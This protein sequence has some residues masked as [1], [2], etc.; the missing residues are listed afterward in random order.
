[1]PRPSQEIRTL[2]ATILS[3]YPDSSPI[4]DILGSVLR[5]L[6]A[7]QLVLVVVSHPGELPP[8]NVRQEVIKA[9]KRMDI[10]CFEGRFDQF[11]P[12]LV[13]FMEKRP[14]RLFSVVCPTNSLEPPIHVRRLNM[15]RE[16][17]RETKKG[18]IFWVPRSGMRTLSMYASNFLDFGSMVDL[19]EDPIFDPV[20]DTNCLPGGSAKLVGRTQTLE[21]LDNCLRD[22]DVAVASL[23]AP[24]GV[25]KSA[26]VEH[27]LDLLK[28][29]AYKGVSKIFGWSFYSQGSHQTQSNSSAFFE[30]ALPFFGFQG[31]MPD[32]EEAKVS[33]LMELLQS[34][35]SLLILDGVEP[36]QYPPSGVQAGR[37]SDIG[38]YRLMRMLARKGLGAFGKNG[39]V[40]I[41]SRQPIE[42]LA[43]RRKGLYRETL[44]ETMLDEDGADLLLS[45]GVH[46]QDDVLRETSRQMHGH[47]LALVLLGFLLVQKHA[48]DILRRNEIKGLFSE[49]KLGDH[50]RWVM[51]YYDETIWP[52]EGAERAFL[53]LL[54]LFDRPLEMAPFKIL[55][56]RAKIAKPLKEMDESLLFLLFEKMKETG[57]V[58]SEKQGES[59]WDAHPLVRAYFGEKLE[60][61]DPEGFR[62]AHRVLFEY[63]QTVPKK[64]QPKTLEKLEPLYRAMHHGC[65]AGEYK[66]ALD[67]V[68]IKRIQQG[69]E[70]FSLLKLGAFGSNLAALSGFFPDG[71]Q[72]P[73]VLDTLSERD[74][75]WLLAEAA[76]CLTSLGRMA[77]AVGPR[78]EDMRRSELLHDWAEASKSA[79]NLCD[80]LMSKGVLVRA[81]QM[82]RQGSNWAEKT[83]S[84]F[85]NLVIQGYLA[86]VLHQL[87]ET[88]QSREAFEKAEK[89]EAGREGGQ[90]KLYSLPGKYY[91]DLLLEQARD[92]SVLENVLKLAE[93]SFQISASHNHLI[94]MAMDYLIQGRALAAL[95]VDG[96]A[97]T[98]LDQAVLTI[99]KAGII[100][101]TP[102]FLIHRADFLYQQREREPARQDLEEALE[103]SER[104][105]LKLY[106]VDGLLLKGHFLLDEEKND[107]AEET[108]KRAENLINKTSYGRRLAELYMLQARWH[109]KQG[110]KREAR[111]LL[112]KSRM[113]IVECEQWGIEPKW[114]TIA[115]E[116]KVPI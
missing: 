44:L 46:G 103:I 17:W 109:S 91:C 15:A 78:Q 22:P 64:D 45:L 95:S 96:F 31:E 68:Y 56:E 100:K 102:E 115:K 70:G 113:R 86:A 7:G 26:L 106:E 67:D 33:L 21:Y 24:G 65:R 112:E 5:R 104:C 82:I 47:A 20:V 69:N 80:L 2:I 3:E 27:W 39:L 54:G 28:E 92:K 51:A 77:E 88:I 72:K 6:S 85:R 49:G 94:S 116:M 8:E 89:L 36:L 63:F 1:M 42:D 34:Q 108:I 23:V 97:R 10:S 83:G 58:L 57:F 61:E 84:L 19:D 55:C 11:S 93:D 114:E 16:N 13:A 50:A 4:V 29:E 60:K 90:S 75:A 52:K 40:L 111:E 105:G 43:D 48:G 66:K 32:T 73:P 107:I 14:E 53:R 12:N 59:R 37:F 35:R 101:N 99:R 9:V 79:A 62:Q 76:F 110:M 74:R 87:G 25:G 30:K 18:I 38:L 71:W 41:T 81:L 98:K